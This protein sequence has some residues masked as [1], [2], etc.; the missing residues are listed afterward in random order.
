M[1]RATSITRREYGFVA[2]WLV[3]IL[4]FYAIIC[5]FGVS[6]LYRYGVETKRE[7][8]AWLES[9][10]KVRPGEARDQFAA[11]GVKPVDVEVGILV[12]KA[13]DFQ[14]REAYW[15]ADFDIWFRWAGDE[16]DPG[17][18]FRVMDGDIDAREKL[19]SE[20]RGT[21]HYER[22][23]V[24]ARIWK[25]FD[26]ARYPFAS[27]ALGIQVEDHGKVAVQYVTNEGSSQIS[28]DAL[29]PV[30]RLIRS[31]G[32]VLQQPERPPWTGASLDGGS[33]LPRPRFVFAMLVAPIVGASYVTMFQGLF[34]SVMIAFLVFFIKPTHVDPRFGLGV[35]AFF[36]AVGSNIAISGILPRMDRASLIG[37]VIGVGVM[38]IFLT[39]VQSTLSLYIYDSLGR[40][41]LSRFFDAVSFGVMFACYAIVNIILP[42]AA[43]M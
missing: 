36:A 11:A 25:I 17:E 12:N 28:R 42:R 26:P 30:L 24:R 6:R 38:T 32:L 41:R 4:A 34:A 3:A 15:N 37:M 16:V 27:E 39:L 29:P 19:D 33:S 23:H 43:M 1:D 35:G 7:R 9:A 2:L 10:T 21:L 31:A 14:L 8:A 22:Y 18:T 13:A 5:S 20:T 40:E